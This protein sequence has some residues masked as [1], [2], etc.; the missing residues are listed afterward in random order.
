MKYKGK[1]KNQDRMPII[2][3]WKRLRSGICWNRIHVVGK[4]VGHPSCPDG[5]SIH[6][7]MVVAGNFAAGHVITTASGSRYFLGSMDAETRV[8]DSDSKSDD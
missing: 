1:I 7:S 8:V 6:T 5:K 2:T 3:G 4:V